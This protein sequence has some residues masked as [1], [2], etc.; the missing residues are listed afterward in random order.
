MPESCLRDCGCL[1]EQNTVI[2][3]L[4]HVIEAVSDCMDHETAKNSLFKI[5][6]LNLCRY[7]RYLTND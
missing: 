2:N 3:K 7:R 4:E 6:A 5:K 1:A